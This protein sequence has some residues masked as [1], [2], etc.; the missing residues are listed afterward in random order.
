MS[1]STSV[2]TYEPTAK[3]ASSSD[4]TLPDDLMEGESCEAA[5]ADVFEETV[6]GVANALGE[7]T[8]QDIVSNGVLAKA[9][10][11]GSPISLRLAISRVCELAAG[12]VSE[13]TKPDEAEDTVAAA[14]PTEDISEDAVDARDVAESRDRRMSD[15]HPCDGSLMTDHLPFVC[16]AD[17]ETAAADP[18]GSP[19]SSESTKAGI[20]RSREI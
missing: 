19:I 18:A 2:L 20:T 5:F 10:A 7:I 14:T 13:E 16:V 3:I 6:E 4:S 12:N 11:A 9:P 17:S 1:L 15:S 8:A